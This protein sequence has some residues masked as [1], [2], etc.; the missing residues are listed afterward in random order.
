MATIFYN[1]FEQIYSKGLVH[2]NDTIECSVCGKTYKRESTATTH[3]NK[4]NCHT[5]RNVFENT[6]AEN[7]MYQIFVSLLAIE[8]KRC[9][10]RSKF[11]KSRLY[12]PI[13]RFMLHCNKNKIMDQGDYLSY[14]LE[15]TYWKTVNMGVLNALKDSSLKE[16]RSRRVKNSGKNDEKF[17]NTN[18]IRLVTDT[19]FV[20]R[21]LE[22]GDISYEYLFDKIGV[23][24]FLNKL[25]NVEIERLE[26]LLIEMRDSS[27]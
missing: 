6:E 12:S 10:S 19:T 13:A 22:R 21:S 26:R 15:S 8:G 9:V 5:Y 14:V 25:N 16:Y 17:F 23:D 2:H 3:F 24:T 18:K 27:L 11:E 7:T 20:L 1:S 4:Q